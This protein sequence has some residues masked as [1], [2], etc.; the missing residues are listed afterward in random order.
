MIMTRLQRCVL[1]ASA[2]IAGLRGDS[3]DITQNRLLKIAE[4]P[5]SKKQIEMLRADYDR[6]VRG[7]P[8]GEEGE[9]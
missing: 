8:I 2:T 9:R 5:L 6:A 3:W 4:G 7:E 1:R